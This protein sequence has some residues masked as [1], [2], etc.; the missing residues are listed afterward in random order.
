MVNLGR[1]SRHS[2]VPDHSRQI[3][4]FSTPTTIQGRYGKTRGVGFLGAADLPGVMSKQCLP[5]KFSPSTALGPA[6][7]WRQLEVLE[8]LETPAYRVTWFGGELI[9]HTMREAQ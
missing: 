2:G 5:R 3:A 8:A 1:R 9:R 6:I 7:T 4:T